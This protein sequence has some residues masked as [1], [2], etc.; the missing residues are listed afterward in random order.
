MDSIYESS[1]DDEYGDVSI[2]TNAPEEIRD[3]NYIHSDI[4]L[5]YSR[6]KIRDR[7]R[8]VQS[9]WK[10]VELSEKSMG[11]FLHKV[12]KAAVK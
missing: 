12:F 11:K 9:K 4:N 5:R 3:R 1:T 2:S 8:Q 6:F 10:G 7:I